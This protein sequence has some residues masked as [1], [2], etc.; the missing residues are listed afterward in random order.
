MHAE[1]PL[2]ELFF[3]GNTV[4]VAQA[5]L[6]HKLVYAQCAGIIVETEAYRD[7]AASHYLTRRKQGI[8]L[9]ETYG[10]VYIYLIYGMYHCLNF[11]T[12][13]DGIGAVLI[14][15]VEPVQGIAAMKIRRRRERLH[16]LTNG[17][18]KVVQAFG[19]DPAH[20][21]EPVGKSVQLVS[22]NT[23][24]DAQIASGP[25]IGISKAQH[26]HWRFWL[27]DNAFVSR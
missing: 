4:S 2:D 20:H 10:C 22:G 13:K 21:G 18:A 3:S 19:I 5:L 7:D 16:D 24:G 26:L 15:A 8:L 1:I 6:G 27:K 9:A 12:E 23:V 25:R 11:T 14:R 17:P